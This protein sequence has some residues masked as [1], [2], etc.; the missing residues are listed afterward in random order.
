MLRI[1]TLQLLGRNK[2]T[3]IVGMTHKGKVYIGADSLGSNGFTQS[4]RKESKVFKNGE[5]LIGCTSSFRMIDL[6]KWKFNPLVI[7]IGER[8]KGVIG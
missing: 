5:F 8:G 7:N 1:I 6:L 4:I 2:L 3:C